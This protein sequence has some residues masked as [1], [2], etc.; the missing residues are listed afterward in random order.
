M[1]A[2]CFPPADVVGLAGSLQLQ[3]VGF[4]LFLVRADGDDGLPPALGAGRLVA[5][6]ARA[7]QHPVT[8]LRRHL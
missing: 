1:N 8:V 2:S 4:L 6:R 7:E 3:A 5:E